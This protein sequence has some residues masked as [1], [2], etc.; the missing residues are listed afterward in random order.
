MG[1][2]IDSCIEVSLVHFVAQMLIIWVCIGSF[3]GYVIVQW[4]EGKQE[5]CWPQDIELIPDTGEYALSESDDYSDDDKVRLFNTS[6]N[7][8]NPIF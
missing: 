4:L 7:A 6:G 8:Y 1:K 2:V 5:N 3:Q